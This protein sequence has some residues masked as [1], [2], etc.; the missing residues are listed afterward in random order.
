MRRR[1]RIERNK[2][3]LMELGLLSTPAG[4]LAQRPAQRPKRSPRQ[5]SRQSQRLRGI[6]AVEPAPVS[7]DVK[8][9]RRAVEGGKPASFAELNLHR[10]RLAALCDGEMQLCK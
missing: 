9:A 6:S 4:P 1:T 10:L 3:K 8:R 2:Q 5:P 7:V